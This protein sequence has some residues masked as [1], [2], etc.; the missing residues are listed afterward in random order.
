M[1]YATPSTTAGDWYL[2]AIDELS[3]MWHAKYEIN[4]ALNIDNTFSDSPYWSS[5]EVNSAGAW[6]FDFRLGIQNSP[7]LKLDNNIVRAVRVF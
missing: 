3:K 7:S 6:G 1:K 5:S 2:P 4:K